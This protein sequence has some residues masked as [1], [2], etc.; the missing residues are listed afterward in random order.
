MFQKHEVRA[1]YT[2]FGRGTS[3]LRGTVP[4][5]VHPC[6]L[7]REPFCSNQM[8]IMERQEF[9]SLLCLQGLP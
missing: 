9:V 8:Q 1:S 3:E 6:Q 4:G 2:A 7:A 5:A